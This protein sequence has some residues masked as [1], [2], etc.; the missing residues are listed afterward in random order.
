MS[1]FEA[2]VSGN[3][4]K[5]RAELDRLLSAKQPKDA[6]KQLLF[7]GCADS[8]QLGED[9]HGVLVATSAVQLATLV[10]EQAAGW[11]LAR[12]V[13]HL[14]TLDLKPLP[15]PPKDELREATYPPAALYA[16]LVEGDIERARQALAPALSVGGFDAIGATLCNIAPLHMEG[17]GHCA[18]VSMAA[19]AAAKL[20]DSG[21]AA[22][23]PSPAAAAPRPVADDALVPLTYA[24]H[25]LVA[26]Y[27]RGKLWG[28]GWFP[29][30]KT[31]Y[32]QTLGRPGPRGHHLGLAKALGEL[33]PYADEQR[34]TSLLR[35]LQLNL[36]QE[37]KSLPAA[38]T[39]DA[40]LAKLVPSAPPELKAAVD[41][42]KHLDVLKIVVANLRWPTMV[43]AHSIVTLNDAVWCANAL[44]FVKLNVGLNAIV[45]LPY[46]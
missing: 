10:G 17:A 16:A 33:S 19:V 22:A 37:T 20:L 43:D 12:A 27:R 6:Y 7:A 4:E 25:Y 29:D 2:I 41:G 42:K 38:G 21:E 46:S 5:A 13:D 44:G 40:L 14:A 24:T 3:G 35:Q 45:S 31:Y 8:A 18:T 32:E 11:V 39:T 34:R 23:S 15:P 9:P 36:Q 28:G 1:L 26:N 30:P